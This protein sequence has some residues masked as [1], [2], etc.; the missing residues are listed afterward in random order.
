M[1]P[2]EPSMYILLIVIVLAVLFGVIALASMYNGLVRLKK[3]AENAWSQ[4]DVQLK[5]RCDLIPNLVETVKG[6]AG[7]ERSV[8]ENVTKARSRVLDSAS[9]GDVGARIQAENGLSGALRG[10]MIQVE[11]YPQLMANENFKALQDELAGTENKIAFARQQYNDDATQY[12]TKRELFPT[13]IVA[14]LFNFAAQ[15]L[16]SI[17]DAAEREVPKVQF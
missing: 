10:L 12:N 3:L 9:G 4:I 14:N 5:R 1:P 16:W 15:T 6:Y 11:A 2:G 8:L 7:H 17:T 13:N